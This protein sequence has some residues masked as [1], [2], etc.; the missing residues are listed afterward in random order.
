MKLLTAILI[1]LVGLF[2]S[3]NASEK[4][5]WRG[6]DQ[7]TWSDFQGVPEGNSS[8]VAS[9]NSGLSFS[10]SY[11]ERNGERIFEYTIQSNFYPKLSWYRPE[12]ASAYIL[13]HE[14]THFDISELHA[15]IFRKRM[16]EF[17]FS[18]KRKEE[19]RRIYETIETERKAMQDRYDEESDHSKNEVGE[20]AWRIFVAEQLKAYDAWR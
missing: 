10:Y 3:E 1:L 9:T 16:A 11:S 15:R 14:Q 17:N 5:P 18:E 13:K 12:A 4:I 8:Y 7:L 6:P 20:R 2:S 19:V